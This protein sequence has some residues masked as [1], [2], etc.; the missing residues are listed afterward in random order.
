[1]KLL[2]RAYEKIKKQPAPYYYDYSLFRII[3]KPVRKWIAQVVAPDCV[4][5]FFRIFLYRLCGFK[6]GKRVFI[7][8]RG[9][10]ISKTSGTSNTDGITIGK[11]AVIGVC[12]LVNK[13]VPDGAA[14]VGV[15]C[16]IVEKELTL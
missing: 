8:M 6:I 2:K 16:R 3:S 10:I 15:P 14:A 11:K 12:T 5:N 4:F 9:S 1:M 13:S 7:G